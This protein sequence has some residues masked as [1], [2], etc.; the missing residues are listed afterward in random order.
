MRTRSCLIAV[1]TLALL[2][3]LFRPA[4]GPPPHRSVLLVTIDTLRAD[5]AGTAKGTPAIE[6]FLREATHF[7]NARTP[8]PL[9]LPAHLTMF[10]GLDPL[11]HGVVDTLAPR[12]PRDRGYALLAEE[13]RDAGF[14]TAAF[15]SCAVVGRATGIDA[16]F[17]TFDCPAFGERFS[18]EMGDMAAPERVKA[19]L[20]WLRARPAGRP[21]FLWVHFYD[22]HEP[23]GAGPPRDA[24]DAEVRRADAAF[25]QLL[26]AVAPET[27][28]LLAS[29]HGESLGEHGEPTHGNLCYSSTMDVLLAARAPG[30]AA[31]AEDDTLHTLHE[32]AASLRTWGGLGGREGAPL[33]APGRGIAMGL[34]LLAHRTHGWGQVLVA[35]D[36]RWSLVESGPALH[37]FDRSRDP[38]E[39]R[40]ME[41]EGH[42]AYERLGRAMAAYR[43]SGSGE[44]GPALAYEESASP[45]GA[46]RRPVSTVLSRGENARLRDPATGFGFATELDRARALIHAGMAARR[47]EPVRAGIDI[48]DRLA[49][50]DAANPAPWELLSHAW[51]ALGDLGDGGLAY[52]RA[53]SAAAEAIGR[54]YT[55]A[56][57]L[58]VVL[59]H[60][61]V[62]RDVA[63]RRAALDLALSSQL[64]PDLH[65]V[66]RVAELAALLGARREGLAFLTRAR[67]HLRDAA[68][69]LDEIEAKLRAHG[70][71]AGE[72]G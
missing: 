43:R 6:G 23:N 39:T 47:P 38:G 5:A 32:V 68:R 30:L 35:F 50:S 3:L 69:R 57:M 51:C 26:R 12:L 24:Y 1:A 70:D 55:I 56:P 4:P 62:S 40:P 53:A 17:D 52:A 37:L 15:A 18:G 41:P 27:V 28:V 45:Y 20:A 7:R 34:S 65:C 10:T 58:H 44:K 48:L 25:G 42:E 67:P 72:G 16:G 46:A 33:A 61:L 21:Y 29:D 19:P 14:E 13:F 63:T 36:G 64:V 11:Q 71:P 31:G 2:G 22:P 54:G 60:A 8:M 9:T 49:D 59:T 66:E